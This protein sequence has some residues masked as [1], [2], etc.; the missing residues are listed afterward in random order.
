[1]IGQTISHYRVLSRLGEGGMGVVY[2]AEDLTL[3]RKVAL[4]FLPVDVAADPEARAR[5][6]HEAQAAAALLHPHIC[7]I[8]EVAESD[9]HAFLAMAYLEGQT[10]RERLRAGPTSLDEA[11]TI[12]RQ[13]GGA[14]AAAH[15]KGVIHRDV[16]PANV[17]LTASGAMLTDFGLAVMSGASRL[18]RTGS[19]VGTAAYLSP[20][21]V[22]G[23]DADERADVWALGV[24][25]YE[26]ISRR[27]PF[28]GEHEQ[29]LFYA[30]LNQD[31]GPLATKAS[32][33]PAG[34]DGILGKALAKDRGK[35]YQRIADFVA[36]LG[37]LAQ[38]REALPAG[39]L[40]RRRPGR[41]ATGAAA[42]MVLALVA[43]AA[44]Q[45]WWPFGG[46]PA[47]PP[48]RKDWILVAEFDGP[49]GDSTLAPAARSLLSAAL[50]QSQM[51]ATVPQEQILYAL[52]T[53]GKPPDS[54]LTPELAKELAYRSA[55]RTV[56]EGT[57]GRLG[58]GYSIVVRLVDA[59]TARVLF[60]GSA[61]AK[62][63]D[64]LIPALGE[65]G[66]KLRR[67][68]GENRRA[69]AATR[70]MIE[71]ATPSFAAY[72]LYVQAMR[73]QGAGEWTD[74]IALHR[75]ALALDPDFAMA[76]GEMSWCFQ[77]RSTYDSVRICITEA[78]RRPGRLTN[79]QRQ[80]LEI[81]LAANEGDGRRALMVTEQLERQD[82]T[83]ISVLDGSWELLY[84][85]YGRFQQA[86]DWQ[87]RAMRL[88]PFGPTEEMRIHEIW[89]LV[90]LGRHDEAR[91]SQRHLT[92][93][94]KTWVMLGIELADGHFAV[95]ESIATVHLDDPEMT[96]EWPIG[97]R[98]FLFGAQAGR[99][100]VKAAAETL[101]QSIAIARAT[102]P[103]FQFA[104]QVH[105]GLL[106]DLVGLM[107]LSSLSRGAVPLPPDTSVRDSSTESLLTRGL[108]A[109]FAGDGPAARS[110]LA[111]ARARPLR[112]LR[113]NGA[114]T[115]MIEARAEL[116]VGRPEEAVRLL[117][118]IAVRE[119][120]PWPQIVP[121]GLAWVR[122]TLADA[123]EQ[124][125]RPDSAAAYLER[126]AS[127]PFADWASPYLHQRLTL[128][129]LRLGRIAEAERH[130]AAAE[131]AWDRPDPAIRRL[132]E[133]ARQA[134]QS[135]RGMARPER[136]R[137]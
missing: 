94:W 77:W 118:P 28:G 31:P 128:L 70:P 27:L 41:L 62:G 92:G 36:D 109:A 61:T 34:L 126:S 39:R 107:T 22:Q 48:A 133:E 51:V 106:M 88:S 26:M 2:L 14:L 12:A 15:A 78:L 102:D 18:T 7:P 72:Q 69:L 85:G 55:V 97:Y 19:T 54:R 120:E 132:L 100:A 114:S 20:E 98:T 74:A 112:E 60:T 73:K 91:A 95:A 16:K 127:S 37:T 130:L 6:I 68:L 29:T 47:P 80:M 33:L 42:G 44:W 115:E 1:M 75:Q 53:A 124:M 129:A 64:A 83:N 38:D 111:E 5:L 82:P 49:P 11:L 87:R 17:M 58:S 135:A 35:R 99:G 63:D 32:G 117:R 25:L 30:I 24:M 67:G 136:G 121:V 119:V 105:Q 59:D 46:Q 76:W 137:S 45:E 66:K 57:I 52:G 56:L 96:R 131:K 89:D 8:Y 84:Y 40:R 43:V 10:L 93:K 125:G 23:A 110:I 86:L 122:W 9:G 71:A 116:Q 103:G 50:D 101:D 134:V 21:Q 79:I 3:R 81:R 108:R 123:F 104:H 65:L 90:G 4:K 13:I 113:M